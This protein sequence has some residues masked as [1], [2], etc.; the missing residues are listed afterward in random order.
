MAKISDFEMLKN[1]QSEFVD[2]L[3]ERKKTEK[4]IP[5]SCCKAKVHRLRLHIQEVML[6]IE[7][8]CDA[9]YKDGKEDW[10]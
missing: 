1:L 2:V 4:W 10:E 7:N 3:N 6:R 8:K 9:Y 5:R